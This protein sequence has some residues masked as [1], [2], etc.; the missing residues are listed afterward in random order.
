MGNQI[1]SSGGALAEVGPASA[2]R[3]GRTLLLRER[4]LAA[5]AHLLMLASLPGLALA[6]LIW[7]TQRRRSAYV[8]AQARQAVLWQVMSNVVFVV[9]IGV[10]VA[11]ALISLGGA[12]DG[13]GALAHRAITGVLGSLLGLYLVLL[14][15][16]LI[17]G[18]SA[19][20][21]ALA[22]LFGWRFHYPFIGRRRRA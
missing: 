18:L 21:G 2:E 17:F 7:L 4:L 3:A 8:A 14:V 22:A 11:A 10:L 13:T 1:E 15:A 16:G 6:A 5:A 12:V 19:V 9:L 20:V